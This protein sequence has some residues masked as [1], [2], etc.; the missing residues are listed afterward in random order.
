MHQLLRPESPLPPPH[1]AGPCSAGCPHL[2]TLVVTEAKVTVLLDHSS[3]CAK[4]ITCT[5]CRRLRPV[6]D[7]LLALDNPPITYKV[8][9][10]YAL[11]SRKFWEK[12]QSQALKKGRV[13]IIV[14][15]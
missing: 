6:L 14:H 4:Y 2:P 7:G 8:R 12:K 10:N 5:A 11:N 1:P 15:T 9:C 13:V 3:L